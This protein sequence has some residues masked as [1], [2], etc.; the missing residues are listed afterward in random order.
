MVLEKTLE[1]PLDSNEIKTVNLKEINPEYSLEGLILKLKLHY[2][3]H[4]MWRADSLEKTLMLGKTEGRR[5]SGQQRMTWLDSITNSID[6]SLSKLREMVKDREVWCAAVHGAAKSQTV[7][8]DWTT[9]IFTCTA[10]LYIYILFSHSLLSYYK[11][12]SIVSCAIQ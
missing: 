5:R 10:K 1:S 12:L 9:T 4:L 3:G 8:S 2:S 6:M 11:I 7:L